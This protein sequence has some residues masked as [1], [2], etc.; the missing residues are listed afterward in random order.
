MA[1]DDEVNKRNCDTSF[2]LDL[3]VEERIKLESIIHYHERLATNICAKPPMIA[4][5]RCDGKC[6]GHLTANAVGYMPELGQNHPK[7]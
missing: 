3:R 1:E 5:L 2:S 6:K 7:R 4:P